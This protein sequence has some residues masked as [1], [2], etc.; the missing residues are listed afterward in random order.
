MTIYYLV[1]SALQ[2]I[3]GWTTADTVLAGKQL[4]PLEN[5]EAEHIRNNIKPWIHE[6]GAFLYVLCEV[7]EN[8]VMSLTS[9]DHFRL[10]TQNE[11]ELD[12]LYQAWFI[13]QEALQTKD[14]A[15]TDFGTLPAWISTGTFSQAETYIE[16]NV[17]DLATSKDVLKK[18]AKV[19]VLLRDYIRI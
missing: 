15:A 3:E 4:I 5:S 7:I 12:P 19:L 14:Q 2:L 9:G 11:L 16:N 6:S 8:P 13:E 18:M 17:V 1:I 10:R